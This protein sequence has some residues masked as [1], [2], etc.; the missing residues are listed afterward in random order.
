MSNE[1]LWNDVSSILL[2]S[3]IVEYLLLL[4]AKCVEIYV[5]YNTAD[6]LKLV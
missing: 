3:S 2:F 5:Y 6:E 1:S 4:I